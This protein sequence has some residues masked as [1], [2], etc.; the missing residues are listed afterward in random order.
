[1]HFINNHKTL[2]IDRLAYDLSKHNSELAVV[3]ISQNRIGS[4]FGVN[5]TSQSLE[6]Y[7][8]QMQATMK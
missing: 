8:A 5:K 7:S 1:M 4:R 2:I 6:R 3:C